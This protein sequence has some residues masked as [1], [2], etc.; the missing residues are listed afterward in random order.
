MNGVTEWLANLSPLTVVIVIVVLAVLRYVLLKLETPTGKS[1]AEIAESLAIAMGLVFLIIRPF[2]VQAFFIPS[3]SMVPTLLIHDHILV[4]KTVYRIRD[5]KPGEIV[6]FKA[7]PEAMEL[8]NPLARAEG[9]QT[10]YIKR[11]VAGPGDE[12]YMAPGYV[13]VNGARWNHEDLQNE[14]AASDEPV[15]IKSDGIYVNGSRVSAQDLAERFGSNPKIE[16]HPGYVVRNGKRL[17]EP[18]LF[19]DADTA[20]PDKTDFRTWPSVEKAVS[21]GKI[22]LIDNGGPLRVKLSKGEFLM[23]G[24]NRNNSLD[25]RYWGPLDRK[26]VVGRAM[27]IFW[28]FSRVH[29]AR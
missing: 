15:R 19:E 13:M 5:P 10:D 2:F 29:W 12:V 6:V 27:F 16:L 8:S 23:M 1:I 21:E 11:V 20:Y 9:K 25:S 7:P 14:L 18:Y 4:N 26:R 22:K 17:S 3:P 28:P 24:D